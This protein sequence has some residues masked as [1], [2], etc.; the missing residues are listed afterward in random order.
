M[1]E[2]VDLHVETMSFECRN[3]VFSTILRG[4]VRINFL[5]EGKKSTLNQSVP[6]P[7]NCRKNWIFP[8]KTHIV[9]TIFDYFRQLSTPLNS[10]FSHWP[11]HIFDSFDSISTLKSTLENRYETILDCH[12]DLDPTLASGVWGTSDLPCWHLDAMW[13]DDLTCHCEMPSN[14]EDVLS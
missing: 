11:T 10:W 12:F 3:S 7:V 2:N 6:P 14:L 13:R 5:L 9:D 4:E 8:L 1:V